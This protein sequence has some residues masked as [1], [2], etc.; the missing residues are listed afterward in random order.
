MIKMK[1]SD[2]AIHDPTHYLSSGSIMYHTGQECTVVKQAYDAL[3]ASVN[4]HQ[5]LLSPRDEDAHT[6]S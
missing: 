3:P 2:D 4:R 5:T 6:V 1:S